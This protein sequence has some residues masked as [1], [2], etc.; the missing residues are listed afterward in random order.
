MIPMP[1]TAMVLAAGMGTRMRPLT[2][3]IPKPLIKVAGK[4]LLDYTLDRFSSAG[5]ERAVV[6]VHYLADAI[7]N[8]L[9]TRTAPEILIS[10]ERGALLETGGGL[11]R[12]RSLLGDGPILCANTDAILMDDPG[13][14]ACSSLANAW[15]G[16]QMDALLL[17]A[18]KDRVTGYDGVG[19]F[20]CDLHGV[21]ARRTGDSAPYI[22][23]GLQILSLDLLDGAPEGPFSTNLL[24]NKALKAGRLRGVI[25]K[26]AWMHVGDPAGLEIADRLIAASKE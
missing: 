7:E 17:L 4:A 24:W 3:N 9:K 21:L 11:K 15:D 19:D 5:V 12:A 26:G 6:N 13:A 25:H 10:D 14:E 23:T 16:D 22:F 20:D 18:E 2:D 8:H 1:D